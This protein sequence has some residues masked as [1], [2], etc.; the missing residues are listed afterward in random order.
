MYCP[1]CEAS[2]KDQLAFCKHL[3]YDHGDP[4]PN[5]EARDLLRTLEELGARLR[6]KANPGL[7]GQATWG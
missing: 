2:R 6:E 3:V 4:L 5:G 7:G 1:G